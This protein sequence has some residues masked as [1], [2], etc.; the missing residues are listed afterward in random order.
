MRNQEND[1]DIDHLKERVAGLENT[2]N[3]LTEQVGE[4]NSI[5]RQL[6]TLHE[7]EKA[8]EKRKHLVRRQLWEKARKGIL[9]LSFLLYLF[10]ILVSILMIIKPGSKI[11]FY[12]QAIEREKIEQITEIIYR[13]PLETN[14]PM[15]KIGGILLFEDGTILQR[16]E[17]S[18]KIENLK[19]GYV[20]D[21]SVP[22]GSSVLF[23]SIDHSDPRQNEKSYWLYYPLVIVSRSL[24]I[25]YLA[26]L[27]LGL[28]IFF[29][30]I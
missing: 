6:A 13:Y 20:L 23:T 18:K 5:V 27:L 24:G 8:N 16:I 26:V 30:I 19:T 17:P 1:S 12:K 7:Q 15:V 2:I 3:S 21:G 9:R 22:E 11:F 4:I 14:K 29:S 25:S 28:G 10:A